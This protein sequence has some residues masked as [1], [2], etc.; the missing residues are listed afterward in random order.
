MLSP[1]GKET[2]PTLEKTRAAIFNI[3]NSRYELKDYSTYD[4]FAGTG[5][6]GFE[7]FSH[8]SNEVIFLDNNKQSC[9]FILKNI[10]QLGLDE[11]CSILFR[12]TVG[13]VKNYDW[14]KTPALFLIDP[15][16]NT[17]LAQKIID[18]L[19][20]RRDMLTGSLMVIETD[21]NH[22]FSYPPEFIIFQQK[23]YGKTRLDFIEI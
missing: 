3:L 23:V 10:N 22:Q 12:D 13:W 20:L 14:K 2:R 16:Y 9:Q 15:P 1:K 18:T 5:A 6:L 19:A 21:K 11:C 4:L 8:G 17:D 7:A